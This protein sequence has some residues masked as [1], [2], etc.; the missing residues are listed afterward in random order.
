M[1]ISHD[2]YEHL[3][4]IRGLGKLHVYGDLLKLY[5]LPVQATI[6]EAGNL[7][8]EIRA[9]ESRI[10]TLYASY[11]LAHIG[12]YVELF[13]SEDVVD[14]DLEPLYTTKFKDED[15][16]EHL[17]SFEPIEEN[18]VSY[19][20]WETYYENEREEKIKLIFVSIFMAEVG[21]RGTKLDAVGH[22]LRK[23]DKSCSNFVI[24]HP[25]LPRKSTK[26]FI[27]AKDKMKQELGQDLVLS[28]GEFV[29]KIIPNSQKRHVIE[30]NW[31][32]LREKIIANLQKKWPI[33]I[34]AT[35]GQQLSDVMELLRRSRVK[36]ETNSFEDATKDAGIAC[37]SLLQILHSVYFLKRTAE[38]LE[39]Y[40]LLCVL[41]EILTEKFGGNVYQDLDFVRTWRNNVVHPRR[42]K[43]DSAITLQVIT[44]AEL[45]N[46]LF[47][48]KI[49]ERNP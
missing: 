10:L 35:Y 2:Q 27:Q 42:E 6:I 8:G 41:K 36:Y 31:S 22:L 45:F 11:V 1:P 46:E 12:F 23:F 29:A 48:K 18:P 19:W 20:E 9:L 25:K 39:F 14:M 49:F 40:D 37:E 3:N 34:F 16:I 13:A 32:T 47:K 7:Y 44:K 30:E 4:D 33:L 17:D 15:W 28:T 24:V 5:A 43:P 38:E 26:M 21:P